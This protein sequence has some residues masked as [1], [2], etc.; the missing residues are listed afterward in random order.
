MKMLAQLQNRFDQW[1]EQVNQYL[2]RLTVR[3]R[4]M[5]VFTTIFVV[6]AIIGASLWK[7]HSLAEQQQ[8]RLNDLKDLMV[9][10]QSNAVT[11]KPASELELGQAEKIQRVAQQQGLTV[12]S[13]Q[14]GEQLQI[15][16]THQNYAILANF[17][18]QLAQMALSIEKMEMVSSEGQIKL[19]ATV[20]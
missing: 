3:E 12:T 1:I 4:I 19:T 18:T 6:V 5:V 7:M 8:Q 11:M 15:I 16:V 2:D 14:N 20:Q 17:L 10:M 13:Q 9:W